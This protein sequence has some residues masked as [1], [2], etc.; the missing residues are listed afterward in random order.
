MKTYTL[1]VEGMTCPHCEQTIEKEVKS[2]FKEVLSVR[3]DRIKKLVVLTVLKEIDL[4]KVTKLI[5]EM[6]YKVIRDEKTL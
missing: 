6:G 4:K 1:K 5:E 3:A 2:N